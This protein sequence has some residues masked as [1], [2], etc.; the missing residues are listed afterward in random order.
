MP[1]A[2][3]TP[4]GPA[5]ARVELTTP[6]STQPAVMLSVPALL[7]A[8]LQ[9]GI[10]GSAPLGFV[11]LAAP[12][13]AGMYQWNNVVEV[14]TLAGAIMDATLSYNDQ[15][16]APQAFVYTQGLGSVG[17]FSPP[18]YSFYSDG[19]ADIRVDAAFGGA[20]GPPLLLDYI[21]S[22]AQTG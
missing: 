3:T 9:L 18:P 7:P 14:L 16:G 12:H 2:F 20:V 1:L 10:D 22:V 5:G 11:L 17:I 19:S 8:V 6:Q 4:D 15:H 21:T 13:P